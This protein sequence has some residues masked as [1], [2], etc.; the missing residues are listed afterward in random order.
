MESSSIRR[1]RIRY[2]N[3]Y[4]SITFNCN[5][6]RFEK[7]FGNYQNL[8]IFLT[9]FFQNAYNLSIFRV[10]CAKHIGFSNI[11]PRNTQN[12]HK[13]DQQESSPRSKKILAA[14]VSTRSHR[15]RQIGQEVTR[16]FSSREQIYAHPPLRVFARWVSPRKSHN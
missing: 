14:I 8:S 1:I 13:I 2:E 9:Y 10:H 11:D 5:F 6:I 16:T 15:S 3:Y 12:A 7:S 4:Y